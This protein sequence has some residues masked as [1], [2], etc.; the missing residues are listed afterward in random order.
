MAEAERPW[1]LKVQL[2]SVV[3]PADVTAVEDAP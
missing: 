3:L 2:F 1:A